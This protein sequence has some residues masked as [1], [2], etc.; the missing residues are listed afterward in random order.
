VVLVV[1]VVGVVEISL[2]VQQEVLV[3][4]EKAILEEPLMVTQEIAKVLVAVGQEQ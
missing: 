3:Q 4:V 1:L 2:E